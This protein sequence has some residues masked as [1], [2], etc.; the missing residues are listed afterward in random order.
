MRQID[1]MDRDMMERNLHMLE[2]ITEY[3]SPSVKSPQI[4]SG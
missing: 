2:S 1:S 3:H 4:R